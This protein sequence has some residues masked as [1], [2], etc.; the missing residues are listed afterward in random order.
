[1]KYIASLLITVLF[2][3]C[4]SKEK[5]ETEATSENQSSSDELIYENETHFSNVKQLTFGGDNAEAYWSFD[6]SML[7]FQ[8]NN[9]DWGVS[10]DQIF[11]MNPHTDDLS[12]KPP[13]MIST[14][15]GR[16]TCAYFLPG[17][18]TFVYG[19]THLGGEDCPVEPERVPGRYV[20][21][22]Y[23]SYD[24]FT[25]DLEGNIINQLTDYE[26]YDAEA[27]L[28]PKG[29]K[30]VFTSLRTGDLE[31][32][33]MNVDG[34]N[35]VQVTDQ[36]GYDGGAFFSPDGEKLVFRSSRPKTEEAIKK[37]KDLL[38]EGLV[39]PSDMEIYTVNIDG[40]ELKQITDLGGANWAPFY[41]PSGERIIFSS[42]YKSQRGYG[43]NLF[44]VDAD[45]GNVEQITH[46]EIFDAFP[47]FSYDGKKLIFSSNRNNGGTHDTNLFLAD[48][49]D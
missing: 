8:S 16:T 28:S 43:F 32:F 31:L 47:M 35:V 9:E 4:T 39:E 30:I 24:I 7:I 6:N 26:G 14:G 42:N 1:M 49:V 10:C 12:A 46:D 20:W 40:T 38:S 22:I 2:F 33:V 34:S 36:L 21:P 17:N 48:W 44:M 27:T 13:K 3:S 23:K 45:G 18:E 19:S 5:E 41:H 25:S 37:Y 11:V 15:L 29:D